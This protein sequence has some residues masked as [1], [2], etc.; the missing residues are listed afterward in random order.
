MAIV[1][2][3][4]TYA[5]EG[6]QLIQRVGVAINTATLTI[7]VPATGTIS[8]AVTRGNWRCKCYN[9]GGTT[10]GVTSIVVN[11]K[12][13]NNTVQIGCYVPPSTVAL[14]NIAWLDV[15]GD[16]IVDTA[17]ASN[18][19]AAGAMTF[20][21]ATTFTFVFVQSGTSPTWSADFEIAAAP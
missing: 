16:F 2:S 7:T 9:G 12:D 18:G 14:T 10:P 5:G 1:N 20:G 11:A 3:I 21:G 13:A 6:F 8:P 19:G 4:A 15:K 17:V